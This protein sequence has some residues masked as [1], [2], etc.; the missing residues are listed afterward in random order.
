MRCLTRYLRVVRVARHTHPDVHSYAPESVTG[1]LIGQTRDLIDDVALAPIRGRAKVYIIDRAE[2]LRP[3]S[4]NA[5]LK[6]LEEPP[7]GVTFILLGTSTETILP[8][9]VSRCQCVPFRM[10]ARLRPPKPSRARRGPSPPAAAWRRPWRAARRAP[11][12]SCAAR[13]ARRRA[14]S[15]CAPSTRCPMP[16][17]WTC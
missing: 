2:R 11:W 17:S 15:C 6:T 13:R 8:T 4:A 16:T 1:Y 7:E 10:I 5:L 3:E 12:S 14:A 9:I